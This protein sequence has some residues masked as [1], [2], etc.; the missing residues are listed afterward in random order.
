MITNFK[1][2]RL[3][4][5]QQSILHAEG[6]TLVIRDQA[7]DNRGRLLDSSYKS[8]WKKSGGNDLSDFWAIHKEM[9]IRKNNGDENWMSPQLWSEEEVTPY[10]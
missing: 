9:E 10:I 2:E 5:Y 7:T 4:L 8:L 6:V 3:E 1:E